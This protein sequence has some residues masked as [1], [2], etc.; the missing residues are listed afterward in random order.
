LAIANGFAEFVGPP[1]PPNYQASG[2][3]NFGILKMQNC[4]INHCR[5]YGTDGGGVYNSGALE[6]DNCVISDCGSAGAY[7]V[8]DVTGGGIYNAGAL[9]MNGCTIG[10]YCTAH[11]GGG[12]Y[13]SGIAAL[14]RC[15]I[16]TCGADE[17]GSGGG[18]VNGGQLVLIACVLTNNFGN[19]SGGGIGGG[20]TLTM[21]N[22]EVLNNGALQ[23]GG[24]DVGGTASCF[25]CA[26]S[27]NSSGELGQYYGG[28]GIRSTAKL[29]LVNCTISGNSCSTGDTS[30]G[31]GG[32][33]ENLNLL[34]MVNCTLSGNTNLSDFVSFPAQGGGIFNGTNAVAYLTDCTV[35]SNSATVG[36]GVANVVG[37]VYAEDSIIANNNGTDF[38]GTLTSQGHNLVGN[39]NACVLAGDLTG[40]IYG[41]DP[42]LGPLQNNGGFALTHAL[43]AG[44]PAIDAGPVNA[45]PL[46][47][48]RGAP[49]PFGPADDIG[50]FEFGATP[51]H[52]AWL[53]TFRNGLPRL[54][55]AGVP[56]FLYMVERA[57]SPSGPWMP[58]T[59]ITAD[60][61]G[62]GV[63]QD[64]NAPSD[65][66]F[67][68][69][70]DP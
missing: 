36:M 7:G 10:G 62:G 8:G 12:I 52:V 18:I 22:T 1:S 47:D 61:N 58:L 64:T 5:D 50:A 59:S 65:H 4:L 41:V 6:L 14:I 56:G 25:N 29:T 30:G 45:F 67:Y 43:L 66:A 17:I 69:V 23:G 68:R 49:R 26:I 48:Q 13:N 60:L 39:T 21:F 31:G 55:I 33:I 11:V 24:L 53:G 42:L 38:S 35:V 27:G 70:V 9:N 19:Y 37:T 63:C 40:N 20:G 46:F 3:R 54:N 32:G 44:S 16:A 57:P 28:G 2:V 15:L 34:T 51:R